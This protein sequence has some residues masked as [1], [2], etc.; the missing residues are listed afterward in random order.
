MTSLRDRLHA[1]TG[2]LL[3]PASTPLGLREATI[4]LAALGREAGGVD[5]LM[6]SPLASQGTWTANGMALGAVYAARCIVDV[7][8]TT[9]FCAGL[10]DAVAA[11]RQ[12]FQGPIRLLYAGCGPYATLV[13]PLLT[14]CSPDELQITLLDLHPKTLRSATRLFEAV[15]AQDLLAEAVCDDA[16]AW[17]P[18]AR[19]PFHVGVCEALQA[20]LGKEPH[21]AITH[22]LAPRLAPGGIWVPES[23][24]VRAVLVDHARED[25]HSLAAVGTDRGRVDFGVV[26]DLRAGGVDAGREVVV[27]GA[28]AWGD[29]AM[30][31]TTIQVYGEHRLGPYDCGLTM[32]VRFPDGPAVLPGR[33]L[34]F[35]CDLSGK[36]GLRYEQA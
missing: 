33:T 16:T 19:P 8:R 24:E 22:N 35:H 26:Y 11:A 14:R 18:G 2:V 36:P 34:R 28:E 32:P 7:F 9:R 15:G 4:A 6:D 12:R 25:D 20:A 1:Q 13:L 3:D 30:L 21:V 10:H 17:D 27:P 23:I 5:T 31:L 29:E